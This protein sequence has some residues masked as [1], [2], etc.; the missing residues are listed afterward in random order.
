MKRIGDVLSAIFD[1]NLLQK[2]EGYSAFFSCWKDITEKNGIAAA[3][4]YSRIKKLERGIVWIEVDHPG[5]KLTLQT[6]QS[7]LLLDF[8]YRFPKLDISGI[9]IIL[10]K[11]GKRDK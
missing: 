10:G 4:D 6:K 3:A 7:K 11:P 2:A 8:Q 9:S 1:E 5:W